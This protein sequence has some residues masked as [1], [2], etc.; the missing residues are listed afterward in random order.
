MKDGVL[1]FRFRENENGISC[2]INDTVFDC[3]VGKMNSLKQPKEFV[4]DVVGKVLY[5][6]TGEPVPMKHPVKKLFDISNKR[7]LNTIYTRIV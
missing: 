1:L 2:G 4:D 7:K 6:N 5:F 3:I